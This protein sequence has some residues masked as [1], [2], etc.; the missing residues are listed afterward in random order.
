MELRDH[1]PAGRV[2]GD[3]P[4]SRDRVGLGS[5]SSRLDLPI[6]R[7]NPDVRAYRSARS[8]NLANRTILNRNGR[9]DRRSTVPL[10]TNLPRRHPDARQTPNNPR[11]SPLAPL[12]MTAGKNGAAPALSRIAHP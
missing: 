2:I 12:R 10:R 7:P 6:L 8:P 5:R 3:D 1:P 11:S 4:A 9:H